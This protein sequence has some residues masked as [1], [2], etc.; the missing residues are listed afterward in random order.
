[1]LRRIHHFPE[2]AIQANS[3]QFP[4]LARA[5]AYQERM[6][7]RRVVHFGPEEMV[8]ECREHRICECGR[9]EYGSFGEVQKS[10]FHDMISKFRSRDSLNPQKI[11]RQMVVQYSPLSLTYASDKLPAFSGLADEMQRNSG[12]EYLAGL[13]RDT[14]ILD[15]CWYRDQKT[16]QSSDVS[17]RAPTWSWASVDGPIRY[18][19][20]FF[21]SNPKTTT[22]LHAE[23]LDATCSLAGSSLTGQVT[24][25]FVDLSCSVFSPIEIRINIASRVVIGPELGSGRLVLDWF[26]DG[27]CSTGGEAPGEYYLIPLATVPPR[28]YR[29]DFF[30]LVVQLIREHP[31]TFARVGLATREYLQAD[32]L[33][34]IVGAERQRVRIV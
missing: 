31:K 11:W 29:Q 13:W 19:L 33:R 28:M 12:Q 18:S 6:L 17:K 25:G 27:R 32:V 20:H 30:A 1:M 16:T 10:D 22:I 23:V 24:G 15:M 4:L 14:L 8:W 2:T 5:W 9:A 21:T 3:V 7:S 34:E 26:P